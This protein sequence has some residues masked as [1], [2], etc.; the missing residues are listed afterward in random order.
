MT[1]LG[2]GIN[3]WIRSI[4]WLWIIT[5][6]IGIFAHDHINGGAVSNDP[7]SA[8]VFSNGD[9]Y[10]TSKGW[11]MFLDG[12]DETGGWRIGTGLT[13]GALPA[14]VSTGG[15]VAGHAALGSCLELE[16]VELLGPKG[17][18][19]NV[20]QR[21]E[22][23]GWRFLLV[24]LEVGGATGGQRIWLSEN[25]GSAGSDPYGHIHGREFWVDQPG[26]YVLKVRLVDTST[27]GTGGGPIH[28]PSAVLSLYLQAQNTLQAEWIHADGLKLSYAVRGHETWAVEE[29]QALGEGAAWREVHRAGGSTQ[30]FLASFVIDEGVGARFYRLRQVTGF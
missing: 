25:D 22:D 14:S 5:G 20:W 8:L 21:Y 18:R 29:S 11:V 1:G 17:A 4:T 28:V 16:F 6:T 24:R 23:F 19:L 10:S 15:P 7:G 2:T 12:E 3:L 9:R 27:Q 13:F 30:G 26:L